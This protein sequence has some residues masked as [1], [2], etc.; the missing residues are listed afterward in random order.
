MIDRWR[1]QA[2]QVVVLVG[3]NVSPVHQVIVRRIT[4]FMWAIRASYATAAKPREI[5]GLNIVDEI[6]DY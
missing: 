5:E 6:N 4:L 1:S 2:L 3:A